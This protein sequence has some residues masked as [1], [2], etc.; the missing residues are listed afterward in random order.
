MGRG[1]QKGLLGEEKRLPLDCSSFIL[2]PGSKRTDIYDTA[3]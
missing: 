2:L 3:L 1:G